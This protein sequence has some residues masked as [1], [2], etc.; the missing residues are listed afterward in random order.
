[1]AIPTQSA[2]F[3]EILSDEL[4][5]KTEAAFVQDNRAM[6]ATRQSRDDEVCRFVGQVSV[7]YAAEVLVGESR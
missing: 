7:V 3:M 4:E 2:I 6:Q 1:M 5:S